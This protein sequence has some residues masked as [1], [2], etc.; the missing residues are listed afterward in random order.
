MSRIHLSISQTTTTKITHTT[1]HRQKGLEK[2]NNN[3][4]ARCVREERAVCGCKL[5]VSGKHGPSAITKTKPQTSRSDCLQQW[6]TLLFK[7]LVL[8]TGSLKRTTTGIV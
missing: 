4:K 5:A 8:S 6:L 1:H 7:P 3:K 2:I